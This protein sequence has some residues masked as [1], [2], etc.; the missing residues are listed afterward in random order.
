M[1]LL[2]ERQVIGAL[3]FFTPRL[4]RRFRDYLVSPYF[5]IGEDLQHLFEGLEQYFFKGK[6]NPDLS[7]TDFW[8]RYAPGKPFEQTRFTHLLFRL[9]E[10]LEDFLALEQFQENDHDIQDRLALRKMSEMQ[11]GKLYDKKARKLRKK[12]KKKAANSLKELQSRNDF[13]M[14]DAVVLI[15]AGEK[16][17]AEKQLKILWEQLRDFSLLAD[18]RVFLAFQGWEMVFDTPMPT[19][20]QA[21]EMA[22]EFPEQPRLADFFGLVIRMYDAEKT[23]RTTLSLELYYQLKAAL[24]IHGNGLGQDELAD[25]MVYAMNFCVRDSQSQHP[26]LPTRKEIDYWIG[27]QTAYFLSQGK[28]SWRD[29][30]N[31]GTHLLNRGKYEEAEGFLREVKKKISGDPDLL[32]FKYLAG[33]KNYYQKDFREALRSFN[34][35]VGYCN[36]KLDLDLVARVMRLRTYY[37]QGDFAA[38]PGDS[39]ALRQKVTR[40]KS[41]MTKERTRTYLNFARFIKRLNLLKTEPKI[42]MQKWERLRQEVEKEPTR[43]KAWLL[44]KLKQ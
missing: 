10:K 1:N 41:E 42:P 9:G 36:D 15:G 4:R 18:Q 37:E 31:H 14:D 43:A 27:K 5:K 6:G 39:E 19:G 8:K 2:R 22:T 11:M 21:P 7:E 20:M 12:I 40:S 13:L 34:H 28:V 3:M 32:V 17:E 35:V 44:E 25:I 33:L 24:E 38:G 30:Q 23:Q 16:G 26:Q 29:V